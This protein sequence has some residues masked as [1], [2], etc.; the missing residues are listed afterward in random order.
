LLFP[1]TTEPEV[2]PGHKGFPFG[3]VLANLKGVFEF[4][5]YKVDAIPSDKIIY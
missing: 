1:I 2:V 3:D 5:N 4:G